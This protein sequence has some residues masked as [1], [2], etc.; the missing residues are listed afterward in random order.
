MKSEYIFLMVI[1]GYFVMIDIILH[2]I[3]FPEKFVVYP[4][5]HL[6]AFIYILTLIFT[7]INLHLLYKNKYEE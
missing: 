3:Y 6:I 2:L 5:N 1:F 7:V 4:Y